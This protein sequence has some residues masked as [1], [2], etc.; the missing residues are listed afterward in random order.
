MSSLDIKTSVEEDSS[1]HEAGSGWNALVSAQ[2]KGKGHNDSIKARCGIHVE[3]AE[4]RTS[5]PSNLIGHH[6]H[7][8]GIKVM[9]AVSG[10]Q[11]RVMEAVF[12]FGFLDHAATN[13]EPLTPVKVGLE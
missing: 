13:V 8:Y 9:T 6:L 5:V 4:R 7:H 10:S 11:V 3:G 12:C 2:E 1:S